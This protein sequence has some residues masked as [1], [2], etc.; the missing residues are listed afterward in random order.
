MLK[1]AK[2]PSPQEYMWL[3]CGPEMLRNNI[4]IP[5]GISN[6]VETCAKTR[7][8]LLSCKLV[9]LNNKI[10]HMWATKEVDLLK[11]LNI[12]RVRKRWSQMLIK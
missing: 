10:L 2:A 8:N 9:P 3:K 11:M 12:S 7:S 4:I 1:I 6:E 5:W